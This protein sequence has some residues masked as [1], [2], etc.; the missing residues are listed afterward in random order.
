VPTIDRGKSFEIQPSA[1]QQPD[2]KV[3]LP[4]ISAIQE[5]FIYHAGSGNYTPTKGRNL[6][7]EHHKIVFISVYQP[8]RKAEA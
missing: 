6:G 5:I 7:N 2:Q 8:F 4:I 3:S 1:E